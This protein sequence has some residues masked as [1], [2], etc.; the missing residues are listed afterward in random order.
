MRKALPSMTPSP[1]DG[2]TSPSPS[3][4]VESDMTATV[5]PRLFSSKLRRLSSRIAVEIAEMP[6]VYQ[7]PNHPK[8]Y[9]PA[10]GIVIIFP[11]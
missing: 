3:T 2:V 7:T 9:T 6:G 10:F 11:P 1:P 8:P 5:L 4:R